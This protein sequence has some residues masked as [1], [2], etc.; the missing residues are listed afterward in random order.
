M[1]VLGEGGCFF[2][3]RGTSVPCRMII[4]SPSTR[5]YSLRPAFTRSTR[6][7]GTDPASGPMISLDVQGYLAHEKQHP[8]PGPP[9]EP[10]YSSPA[11]GSKKRV[12]Y[13]ERGTPVCASSLAPVQGPHPY[14]A[15]GTRPLDD[16]GVTRNKGHAPS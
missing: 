9:Y 6:K 3:G 5:L 14:E 2:Y 16:T 13:Y 7:M 12:A 11:V 8:L 10:R 4:S 15:L 1:L